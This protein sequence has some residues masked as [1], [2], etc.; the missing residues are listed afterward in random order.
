[1]MAADVSQSFVLLAWAR[2]CGDQDDRTKNQE[3]RRGGKLRAGECGPPRRCS[4]GPTGRLP[5][6]LR[7]SPGAGVP[8]HAGMVQQL[9][10]IER[11]A[12]MARGRRATP[13][14]HG[15]PRQL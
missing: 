9:P 10:S 5:V 14:R 4:G 2:Q 13:R 3:K 12:V 8:G 11:K 6:L 1:W 7:P 15:S